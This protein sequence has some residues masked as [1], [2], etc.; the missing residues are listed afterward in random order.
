M[1]SRSV[2]VRSASRMYLDGVLKTIG[3][4]KIRQV[5]IL[6][7]HI[8]SRN[9]YNWAYRLWSPNDSLVMLSVEVVR[10]E[11]SGEGK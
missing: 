10:R 1:A 3:G 9:W 6:D 11:T 7:F 8:G 2:C 4:N 5:Q